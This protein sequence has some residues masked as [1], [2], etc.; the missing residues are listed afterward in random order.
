MKRSVICLAVSGFCASSATI[1]SV[2][3]P[4]SL[5]PRCLTAS[6]KPSRMSMPR[7]APEP[8]RVV[9]M[10]TFMLSAATAA[11]LASKA[12]QARAMQV[13]FIIVFISR[14]GTACRRH[15][16]MTGTQAAIR[17]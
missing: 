2:A 16:L 9:N 17:P 13:F 10:P 3:M 11:P 8:D 12:E 5:P 1:T 7:P 14:G 4:P 6:S 15:L